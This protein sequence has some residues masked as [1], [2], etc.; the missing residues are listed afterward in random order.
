MAVT[1]VLKDNVTGKT[2]TFNFE[3][4]PTEQDLSDAVDHV[5]KQVSYDNPAETAQPVDNNK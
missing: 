2:Y 3:S 5:Q 1:K 4:E